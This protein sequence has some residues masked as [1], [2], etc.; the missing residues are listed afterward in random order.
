MKIKGLIFL[1]LFCLPVVSHSAVSSFYTA[2]DLEFD[3]ITNLYYPLSVGFVWAVDD[4]ITYV[5]LDYYSALCT[6]Y[7]D[8]TNK[9]GAFTSADVSMER[10]EE[11]VISGKE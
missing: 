6:D 8:C 5:P 11:I 4:T 9:I 10:G 7:P 2:P 3:P 1:F